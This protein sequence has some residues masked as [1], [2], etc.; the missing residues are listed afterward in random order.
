MGA[1]TA[2]TDIDPGGLDRPG[3]MRLPCPAPEESRVGLDRV[4]LLAH[5][6]ADGLA[7]LYAARHPQRIRT[8][9]LITARALGADFTEAHR[10][11]AAALRTAE[12][13]F[14][15]AYDACERVWAGS[16]SD[17]DWDAIAPFFYARWDAAAQAHAASEVAQPHEETAEI[18]ASGGAFAPDEARAAVAGMDARVLL[19]AGEVDSGPLRRIA[20]DIAQLIPRA[21]LVVQ[22]GA[23]HYPWLD[24][25]R[26]FTGTVATFLG[27]ESAGLDV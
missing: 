5:S 7:L 4:D 10:R 11:A 25:P 22:P 21:E 1:R 20:A 14:G 3:G 24:D 8:L 18:Y 12:P 9:T 2:P 13:W 19:L 26:R 6:A 16:V 15:A 27:R 17:A 23:G